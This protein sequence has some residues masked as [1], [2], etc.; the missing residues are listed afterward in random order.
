[1]N[2]IVFIG[3]VTTSIGIIHG[4][5]LSANSAATFAEMLLD[6]VSVL[7]LTWCAIPGIASSSGI[8][9]QI[10]RM[11]LSMYAGVVAIIWQDPWVCCLAVVHFIHSASFALITVL[12]H[13]TSTPSENGPGRILSAIQAFS[14]S[15]A[16]LC[17][18][19]EGGYEFRPWLCLT[20]LCS[21]I[22]VHL[23]SVAG[24]WD[25]PPSNDQALYIQTSY[26]IT[27]SDGAFVYG[28]CCLL[29]LA[30]T[31]TTSVLLPILGD[32]VCSGTL[33]KECSWGPAR[34]LFSVAMLCICY[35]SGFVRGTFR[36]KHHTL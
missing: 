8:A 16:L 15:V 28:L 10:C 6:A 35:F 3:V 7:V 5:F 25:A 18:C 29:L 12:M 11:V 9:L 1:M 4:T 20:L 22:M 34:L 32:S 31:L 13:K 26:A 33:S 24:M 36:N 27:T 14:I 21:F 19:A 2:L 17:I 23:S 30:A